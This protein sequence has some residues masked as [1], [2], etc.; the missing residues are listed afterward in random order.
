MTVNDGAPGNC[1][2]DS[3]EI[4]TEMMRNGAPSEAVRLVH[5]APIGSGEANKGKRFWHAWVESIA[6]PKRPVVLSAVRGELRAVERRDFYKF[7]HLD[8]SWVIRYTPDEVLDRVGTYVHAGPWM[9]DLS[10]LDLNERVDPIDRLSPD[11][12]AEL[13]RPAEVGS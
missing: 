4:L 10:A 6:D 9:A 5:G 12:I 3:I 2:T 8:N 11:A 13:A 7:G 1:F